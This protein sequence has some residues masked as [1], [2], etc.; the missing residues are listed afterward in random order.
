MENLKKY[1]ILYAEDEGIIRL[2]MGKRLQSYCNNVLLAKDGQEAW[3]IYVKERP[4]VLILDINMPYVSGLE[5][6]KK[7]RESNATIPILLLT[8]YTDTNIFLEAIELNLC[9]YLV[10]P[11][12]KVALR[13]A[14]EKISQ[15]LKEKNKSILKL[16][17]NYSWDRKD[18]KLL[19]NESRVDLTPRET[20]L[21]ELLVNNQHQQVSHEEILAIVWEDKFMEE[22]SKDSVKTLMNSLRKKIPKKSI[23]SVY[24]SGYILL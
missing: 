16:E 9:K 10:K 12:G 18:K 17:E 8:A 6:A 15:K 4:D 19:Q 22:I 14:L 3:N 7:V 2:S 5:L 24:G 13:E 23:K 11:V 21:L 1:T 20:A